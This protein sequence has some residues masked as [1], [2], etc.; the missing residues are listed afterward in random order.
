MLKNKLDITIEKYTF[1][2]VTEIEL[3][4][5]VYYLLAVIPQN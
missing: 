1:S 3:F 2:I 4:G 5:V